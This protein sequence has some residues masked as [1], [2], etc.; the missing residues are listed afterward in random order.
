MAGRKSGAVEWLTK[1]GLTML[2]SFARDG[3][4]DKQIAESKLGVSERTFTTWKEKH[5]SIVSALKKGK[6][7]VDVQVENMLL[8]SAMGFTKTVQEPMK[9]RQRGGTEIVE[10]VTREIYIP[11][12]I[13]AQIFW[14][15]NRKPEYW[16][17]KPVAPVKIDNTDDGFLKALEETAPDDW[18][19]PDDSTDDIP[20]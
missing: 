12:N 1:D 6:A 9:L 7:P 4:T 2:E 8:R 10:Y 19:E 20:I 13:T 16:R 14:L 17:D 18:S 5:P 11:P 15:K 3:L